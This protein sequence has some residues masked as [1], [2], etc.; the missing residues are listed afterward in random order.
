MANRKFDFKQCI[1]R[2]NREVSGSFAP[3]GNSALVAANT[4]GLG[5]TV[6][7]ISTGLYRVT[8]LNQYSTLQSATATLQLAT[9]DDKFVQVGSYDTTNNTID[10]RV[11]DVSGN[12]VADVAADANNR[13][14]FVFTFNDRLQA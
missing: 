13:I 2:N 14:S 11:W 5:F 3:N 4:Y 6:A 12:D 10:I 1:G 9:K 8:L 7:Y